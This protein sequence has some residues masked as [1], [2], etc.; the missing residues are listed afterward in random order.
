MAG[1]RVK[2]ITIEIE[3]NTTKLQSALSSVNQ[4]LK[5]TQNSLRDVNNLLKLDPTNTDL[6]KQKQDLL[7]NAIEDT[8]QKLETEKEALRQLKEADQTP[9]V[10]TQQQALE[11]QI[12]ADETALQELKNETGAFKSAGMQAFFAVGEKVKAVGEKIKSV[13]EDITKNVTVPLAAIGGASIAAFKN[14][15]DGYDEMIKKTGAT[16]EEA[17][18]L[19]EIMNGI[20]TEI[21]T[22]FDTAG[23]AIGE[24][25][26]RF[27]VTGDELEQLSSQFIKFADLNNTDVSD[28]VDKVQKALAAY[29]LGAEDAGSFLDRLNKTGQETGISVDKLADGIVNNGAALQEMGLSI[30]QAAGFMGKL[31]KSGAN[32]DTVMTGMRKALKN[33]TKEGKPLKTALSEL[34][35][36]IKNGNG[37]MDGLT[38]AYDLFG[39]SGDRIYAAVQNG[40]LDFEALGEAVAEAGGSVNDTFAETQDPLD[41][42]QT[43]LN[44]LKIVGAE[45]GGTL[46]ETLAPILEK[47]GEVLQIIKEKW[48]ELDPSTQDMIVKIGLIVA[49]IGPVIMIIGSLVSAIGMLMSPIGLVVLAIG[50]A[51]AAGVLLYQNWD[52]ICA[53]AAQLKDKIIEAWNTI[54]EK[55]VEFVTNLVESVKQKWELFKYIVVEVTEN[56]KAKIKEKFEELKDKVVGIWEA[57]KS[58]LSEI[59]ENIKTALHEK[60]ESIKSKITGIWENV[61]QNT[62]ETWSAIKSKIEENGGGIEGVIRTAVDIYKSIWEEGF[63]FL[64]EV[65]GGKLSSIFNWFEDKFAAIKDTV[66]GVVEWLK[67]IFDFEWSL[68]DIKLPH[69]SWEW[70]DLGVVSLPHISVEWYKKAY[71]TPYLFTDP[72]IVGGRGFGDGGGSGELV[73]GRDQL[74]R[75]IAEASGGDEITINVY[76]ADGMNINELAEEISDRLTFVQ[77]QRAS[78]YA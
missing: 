38:A 17:E 16:G 44:E 11:R 68:P 7:K 28:S 70:V 53:W 3:G 58:K 63:N 57:F 52:E 1:S 75:D 23:R 33:A 55:V 30:D 78:A 4:D 21:P 47:V 22:D 15:D 40:T 8:K 65:T 77:R 31:E 19:R 39:N 51:I 66:E 2:G 24:V 37:S 41:Q 67:G 71:D 49:A 34:Q 69:F 5:T 60:F 45:L 73:Y 6:L 76:A 35:E 13:G 9:E 42:F 14:V 10:I 48:D 59:A 20:A 61:K 25:S 64:D 18:K 46:L 62:S 12:A 27:G 43:T 56:M 36:T 72:T 29:G 32:T 74:L 26:T 54:K 50:A